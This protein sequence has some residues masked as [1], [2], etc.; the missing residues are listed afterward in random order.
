[1]NI[2]CPLGIAI[3]RPAAFRDGVHNIDS[4]AAPGVAPFSH[5]SNQCLIMVHLPYDLHGTGRRCDE[6]AG[7]RR[8]GLHSGSDHFDHHECFPLILT[9]VVQFNGKWESIFSGQCNINAQKPKDSARKQ[10]YAH[11]SWQLI[12]PFCVAAPQQPKYAQTSIFL[13]R[14]SKRTKA[15]FC[16]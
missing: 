16:E 10:Y 1:M 5:D 6:V 13:R 12:G 15:F 14:L 7:L 11:S 4:E 3:R 2:G 9:E 8:E